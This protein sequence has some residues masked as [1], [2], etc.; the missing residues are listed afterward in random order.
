MR[1]WVGGFGEF[2]RFGGEEGTGTWSVQPR[3]R[4][5]TLSRPRRCRSGGSG[6]W[7]GGCWR[8]RCSEFAVPL[9]LARSFGSVGML[10]RTLKDGKGVGGIIGAHVGDV[11]QGAFASGADRPGR[12]R[13]DGG[14]GAGRDARG[15]GRE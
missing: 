15:K 13:G 14:K 2:G 11:G 10:G 4:V 12:R 7:R 9:A 8:R 6:R 3:C 5:N 1:G